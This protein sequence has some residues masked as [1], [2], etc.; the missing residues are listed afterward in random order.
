MQA[1]EERGL[2]NNYLFTLIKFVLFLI[3]LCFLT[4]LT[5]SFWRE[6]RTT[7]GFDINILV[8]SFVSAFAFYTFIVDLNN[9]YKNIQ[10]FFFRSTFFSVVFPSALIVLSIGYFFLPKILNIAFNKDIF[11]FAGG[12][13]LTCHLIF[14]A[15]ANKGHN[16]ASVINYF[17]IF[18]ILFMLNLVILGLYLKISFNMQLNQVI[19]EGMKDGA[20][21]IQNIFTQALR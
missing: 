4:E 14:V 6:L 1:I 15:S 13:S 8:L 18:S 10:N 19:L 5:K 12:F 21:L 7:E 11:I 3:I 9:L 2:H 16:F 20:A 17:F